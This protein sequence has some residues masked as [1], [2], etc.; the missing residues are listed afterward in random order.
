M[1][2]KKEGISASV[3]FRARDIPNTNVM[4]CPDGEDI[5]LVASTNHPLKVWT[6]HAPTSE[7]P[8]CNCRFVM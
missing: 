4:L 8:Q 5:V 3:V 7:W 2:Q 1:K 6:I